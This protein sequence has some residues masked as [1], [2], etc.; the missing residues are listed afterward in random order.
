MNELAKSWRIWVL[1]IAIFLAFFAVAANL[2]STGNPFNFGIDF[3]GGTLFQIHLS[4]KVP[5]IEEVENIIQNRLNWSGMSDIRVYGAENQFI[6]VIV[7]QT[8]PQDVERIEKLIKQQGRF[9]V[10]IDAN[11]MFTG[12]DLIQVDQSISL[13]AFSKGQQGGYQWRLPFVLKGPA[14]ERFM[15]LSFHRCPLISFE[16]KQYDCALTYF[17]IDRPRKAVFIFTSELFELDKASL[18]S[19]NTKIGIPKGTDIE[20]VLQNIDAPYFII[21]KKP[22]EEQLAELK[23][24]LQVKELAIIPSSL[25]QE[26]RNALKELGFEIKEFPD[27]KDKPLET[28]EPWIWRASGLQSIVR[29][30]PSITGDDPYVSSRSQMQPITNLQVTGTAEDYQAAFDERNRIKIIL[31]SGSLPVS[32]ES[33]SSFYTSPIQGFDFLF[34]AAI[35][36]LIVLCVVS[37][38]IFLR[39]RT[40]K[41]SLAI[42]FTAVVEAFITTTLTSSLGGNIDLAAIAGIIA[43]VGTGVDDQIVITDELLRGGQKEERVSLLR[44]VK[45]AFFIVIAAAATTLAT[46]LPIILFGTIMVRLIGFAIAITIGVLVGVFITRPAYGEIAKFLMSSY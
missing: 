17:F 31:Q 46:M 18:K 8:K 36:G 40:P 13:P 37:V 43:A 25:N 16:Q 20:E 3:M 38:I 21:D 41:L 27:E 19:G 22:T 35:T 32:V 33:I 11:V 45:N 15:D 23:N 9:E 1:F 7:P 6:F 28:R 26:T 34:K 4:E 44:R 5:N 14:A 29:L 39:Y 2:V 42:I 10:L 24:V 12:K 30:T